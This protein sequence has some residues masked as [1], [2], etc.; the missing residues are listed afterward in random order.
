MTAPGTEAW[1]K[2]LHAGVGESW[3]E[4]VLKVPAAITAYAMCSANDCPERDPATWTLLGQVCGMGY[5]VWGMGYG[6][7]GMVC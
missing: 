1:N 2:W 7:C 6:V 5:G 4:A 3:V